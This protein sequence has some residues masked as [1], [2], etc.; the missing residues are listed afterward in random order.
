[1]HRAFCFYLSTFLF[2]FWA[3]FLFL[4]WCLIFFSQEQNRLQKFKK[5]SPSHSLNNFKEDFIRSTIETKLN[6]QITN[7]TSFFRLSLNKMLPWIWLLNNVINIPEN[8]FSSNY[9]CLKVKG[10]I[11]SQW[12]EIVGMPH[13]CQITNDVLRWRISVGVT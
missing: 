3:H 5:K 1:M 10:G 8:V 7:H 11:L 12:D 13:N 4:G 9:C 6:F 2:F